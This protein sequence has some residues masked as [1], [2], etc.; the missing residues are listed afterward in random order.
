MRGMSVLRLLAVLI[1]IWICMNVIVPE[2]ERLQWAVR[3]LFEPWLSVVRPAEVSIALIVVL[4]WFLV[5][6]HRQ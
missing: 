2:F 5:L 6:R 1:V 3:C 4:Y